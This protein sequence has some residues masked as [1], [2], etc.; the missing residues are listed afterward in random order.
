MDA[1]EIQRR[2]GDKGQMVILYLLGKPTIETLDRFLVE[3]GLTPDELL[4]IL[5][6]MEEAGLVVTERA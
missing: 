6:A 1:Q 4:Q 5:H 2:F 3:S